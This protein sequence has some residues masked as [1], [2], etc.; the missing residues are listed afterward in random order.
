MT[1]ITPLHSLILRVILEGHVKSAHKQERTYNDTKMHFRRSVNILDFR[2][3]VQ[4][5]TL[6]SR[7]RSSSTNLSNTLK[8]TKIYPWC[9]KSLASLAYVPSDSF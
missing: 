7:S 8:A 2:E 1:D 4:F 3:A 6:R 5:K 9:Q